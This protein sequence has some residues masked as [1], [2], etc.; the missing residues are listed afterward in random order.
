MNSIERPLQK[1]KTKKERRKRTSNTAQDPSII[2]INIYLLV[3]RV[4]IQINLQLYLQALRD[5][6]C[7]RLL[8]GNRLHIARGGSLSKQELTR[9]LRD[10]LALG[11][12]SCLVAIVQTQVCGESETSR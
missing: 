7:P 10:K 2:T 1:E 12:R 4:E 3:V 8:G 11:V 6:G 9:E 5:R